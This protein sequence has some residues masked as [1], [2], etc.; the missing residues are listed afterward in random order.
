[1]AGGAKAQGKW[2][3][4]RPTGRL[5]QVKGDAM[6]RKLDAIRNESTAMKAHEALALAQFGETGFDDRSSP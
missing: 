6:Q 3:E 5:L 2:E 4:K 1:L